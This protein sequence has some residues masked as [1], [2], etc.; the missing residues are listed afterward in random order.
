MVVQA[1]LEGGNDLGLG[2]AQATRAAH[3]EYGRE[4]KARLVVGIE[5]AD[6]GQFIRSA[7]GQAR[8]ALLI[9]RF[10]RERV[11]FHGLASQLRVSADQVELLL[12]AAGSQRLHHGVLELRERPK[13]ALCQRGLCD[14]R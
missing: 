8:L 6:M 2:Q 4:A 10:G 14:P 1:A 5:L 9:G 7:I 12:I 11:G 3:G 13:G